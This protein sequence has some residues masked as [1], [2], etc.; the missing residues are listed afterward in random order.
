[1]QRLE[2]LLV[3]AQT[4]DRAAFDRIHTALEKRV[5]RF[6][7]RLTADSSESGDITQRAFVSLWVNIKRIERAESLL[8]Y[9]FRVVRNMYYDIYRRRRRY[10]HITLFDEIPNNNDVPQDTAFELV[11]L[12][13]QVTTAIDSLP[14]VHR[15]TIILYAEEEFTYEQ[16]AETMKVGVGT[17][18]SRIYHARKKLRTMLG[19]EILREFG[20]KEK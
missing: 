17:V 14:E 4:G 13:E 3:S 8:P 6:T 1:M 20:V 11:N 19:P 7:R 16:I 10:A 12:M 15:Q 5:D 18:K 2:T 9:L